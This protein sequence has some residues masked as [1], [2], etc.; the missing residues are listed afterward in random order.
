MKRTIKLFLVVLCVLTVLFT[1]VACETKLDEKTTEQLLGNVMSE[2]TFSTTGGYAFKMSIVQSYITYNYEGVFTLDENKSVSGDLVYHSNGDVSAAA[3]RNNKVYG[4]DFAM[5]PE[6]DALQAVKAYVEQHSADFKQMEA[7]DIGGW[8]DWSA[9]FPTDIVPT[10]ALPEGVAELVSTLAKNGLVAVFN[11]S[12]KT[13]DGYVLAIDLNKLFLDVWAKVYAVARR[14]D[15]NKTLTVSE[16]W[17]SKEMVALLKPML[18]GV[19][20]TQIQNLIQTVADSTQTVLPFVLP[21]AQEGED[22]MNYVG[23]CLETIKVSLATVGSL[24]VSD[25]LQMVGL[26]DVDLT[27]VLDGAR[28]S[29]AKTIKP[30]ADGLTFELHFDGNKKFVG[31]VFALK[32]AE[33]SQLGSKPID[34]SFELNLAQTAPALWNIAGL[35][36]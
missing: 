8:F 23:R 15:D 17:S 14:I 22:A 35:T 20:G 30:I 10:D 24:R 6:G 34:I 31:V 9:Q 5:T 27:D 25:I 33:N 19:S 28:E 21:T 1:A 18:E 11:N 4:M 2:E 29:L 3:I 12:K 32:L 7:E 13:S 36:E 26:Q 16:L